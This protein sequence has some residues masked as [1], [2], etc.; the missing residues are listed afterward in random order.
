M[1]TRQAIETI[2]EGGALC[3]R[4]GWT[5]QP[6][7]VCP[8]CGGTAY[9]TNELDVAASVASGRLARRVGAAWAALSLPVAVLLG[10]L[11]SVVHE[12]LFDATLIALLSLALAL[13]VERLW[14]T[15]LHRTERALL[16]GDPGSGPWKRLSFWFAIALVPL[17]ALTHGH[18]SSWWLDPARLW[19]GQELWRLAS[20]ALSHAG[21]LHL[22]GNLLGLALFAPAV[23]QR[24]GPSRWALIAAVTMVA[25]GLAHAAFSTVP[26]VGASGIV[27]GF[28]GAGLALF[29]TRKVVL[30]LVGEPIV[31]PTWVSH[32]V[33]LAVFTLVD[34]V[35]RP[36]VAWVAHLG[37]FAA[38]VALGLLFRR[39]PPGAAFLA[40]EARREARI[41]AI[42]RNA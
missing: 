15:R 7:D 24:V 17:S 23:E 11:S 6:A 38:G 40:A 13:P 9:R 10:W 1:D 18:L 30:G 32:G 12:P 31:V 22:A 42:E 37:G 14:R 36:Q 33:R 39:V 8:L 3:L 4:C 34:I 16:A 19:S 20:S 21:L 2:T 41:A 27:Y 28:A 25:A 35:A 29:P 26:A 5:T